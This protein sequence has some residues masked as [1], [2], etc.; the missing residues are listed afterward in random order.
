[1]TSTPWDAELAAAKYE[2][3]QKHKR[4][5]MI[6]SGVGYVAVTA[7]IVGGI[8]GIVFAIYKSGQN[9]GDRSVLK[10]REQTEQVQ[11]CTNLPEPIERQYCLISIQEPK[12]DN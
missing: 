11:Y 12:R 8:L 2:S 6:W 1:M 10:E 5:T 7:L 9:G 4:L 3:D